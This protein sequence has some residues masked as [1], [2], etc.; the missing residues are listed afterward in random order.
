[1][2]WYNYIVFIEGTADTGDPGGKPYRS[3]NDSWDTVETTRKMF[4]NNR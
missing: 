1:M 3:R 4:S 2:F